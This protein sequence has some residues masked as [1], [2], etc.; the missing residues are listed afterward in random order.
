MGRAAFPKT[1]GCQ[2]PLFG[3]PTAQLDIVT[4]WAARQA[5]QRELGAFEQRLQTEQRLA[6]TTAQSLRY[7]LQAAVDTADVPS[8][9]A[10][11]QAPSRVVEGIERLSKRAARRKLHLAIGYFLDLNGEILPPGTAARL[12]TALDEFPARVTARPDLMDRDLGGSVKRVRPAPPFTA[13][14][15]ERLFRIVEETA[16]DT[17][18]ARDRVLMTLHLWSGFA[19]RHLVELRW[20]GVLPTLTV[21]HEFP[22]VP[23]SIRGRE[24]PIVVHRRAIAALEQYWRASGEPPR[25]PI[26]LH[27]NRSGKSTTARYLGDV[28]KEYLADVQLSGVDRRRLNAPFAQALLDRDWDDKAVAEAFGYQRVRDL[29]EHVRSVEE[30]QAQRRSVEWLTANPSDAEINLVIDRESL[31][32]TIPSGWTTS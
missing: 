15:A 32:G 9:S 14:D 20:E 24:Y 21:D 11:V 18:R 28:V 30:A 23:T 17:R 2:L 7:Q 5:G 6:P 29:Q 26:F 1:D 8:P 31:S 4:D 22:R 13:A 12:E 27:T 25:G 16:P 19:P 10:F 3:D